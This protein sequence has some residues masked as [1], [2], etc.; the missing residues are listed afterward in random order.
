MG[1]F[2]LNLLTFPL[3]WYTHGLVAVWIWARRRAR[4]DLR[5]TGIV[6]FS[7]HLSE[8]LFGDYTRSGMVVGFFLRIVLLFGKSLMLLFRF[9]LIAV[10]LIAYL[11]AIPVAIVM[12]INQAF[13]FHG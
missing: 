8:P 9:A 2:E 7:R 13:L 3:W 4:Y 5:A 12:I 11:L 1:N 10:V 6:L